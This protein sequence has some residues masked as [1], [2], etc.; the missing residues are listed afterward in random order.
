MSSRREVF[1]RTLVLQQRKTLIETKNSHIKKMLKT[2]LFDC[3]IN[4]KVAVLTEEGAFALFF[5]S[6]RVP[7]PGWAQLQLTDALEADVVCH[8]SNVKQLY[9][10]KQSNAVCAR[11]TAPMFQRSQEPISNDDVAGNSSS[12]LSS[13]WRA[14][15]ERYPITLCNE[16]YEDF[17]S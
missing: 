7:T 15:K 4:E 16:L 6:S 12:E 14:M 2:A 11:L 10:S 8:K 13:R 17:R 9:F 1:V 5:D 3:A